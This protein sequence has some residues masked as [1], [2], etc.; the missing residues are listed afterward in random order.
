MMKLIFLLIPISLTFFS[1]SDS[2]STKVTE[3]DNITE[4]KTTSVT[5]IPRTDSI[6]KVHTSSSYI[7]PIDQTS[8]D[9]SLKRFVSRLRQCV[10]RKN[11]PE[12]ISCLDTGIV[13]SYGGGMHGI[14][15]FLDEWKLNKQA[16]KSALWSKMNL[17]LDLGGAWK[18]HQ[19][20]EFCF[21][22]PQSDILFEHIDQDLDWYRTAVCISPQTIVYE[23]AATNS[24]KTA[25]L[26]YEVL[27]IMERGDH[28]IQI[29]TLDKQV[30]G[31]V[32]TEQL[33][34]SADAY[35]ILQKVDGAWKIVSFAPF[36]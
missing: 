29:R 16:E 15:T 14:P 21:P 3:A 10:E 27:E 1:C 2:S 33:I 17:F 35:P 4:K 28:F 23:K 7:Y 34:L 6:L 11:L 32:K 8:D 30:S 19:K 24:K 26:S 36:D 22:Y 9:A 18:D 31:F 12:F 20:T 5:E 25:L 13:V